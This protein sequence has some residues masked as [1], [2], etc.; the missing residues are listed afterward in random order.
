MIM[1]EKDKFVGV[2]IVKFYVIAFIMMVGI[3]LLMDYVIFPAVQ[4]KMAIDGLSNVTPQAGRLT[5]AFFG[6]YP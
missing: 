1:T 5:K 4:Y 3:W 6:G 2:G